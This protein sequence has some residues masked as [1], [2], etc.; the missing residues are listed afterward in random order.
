MDFVDH[1]QLSYLSTQER[2]GVLQSTLV[3]GAFQ[4]KVES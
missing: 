4:I 1:N 2:I 3:G